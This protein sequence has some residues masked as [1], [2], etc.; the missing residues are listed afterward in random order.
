MNHRPRNF[1]DKIVKPALADLVLACDGEERL[2]SVAARQLLLLTAAVESDFAYTQQHGGPA[3]SYFQIEELTYN[4]VVK[5]FRANGRPMPN[6]FG[7]DKAASVNMAVQRQ[8]CKVA[9]GKYWL[10]PK[11]MPR[12]DDWGGF[13]AYWKEIYNTAGGAGTTR[14]ALRRVK[15][16]GLDTLN[17]GD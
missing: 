12:A 1:L 2:N 6:V 17:Y 5:R 10:S 14:K 11:P 15:K 16:Y 7:F 3:R 8:C 9:R 13:A 4:D